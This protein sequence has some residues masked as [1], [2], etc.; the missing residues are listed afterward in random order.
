MA[1]ENLISIIVPV[2]KVE[3]FLTKCVNSICN[4]TYKQLEIILVDDGSPDKC[5]QMCDDYA[6]KDSRVRVIHQKN[7]GLSAARNSGIDVARGKYIM[8]VDSDDSID[9]E[10]CQELLEKM[11]TNDV[12]IVSFPSYTIRYGIVKHKKRTG[13]FTIKKQ[14][15]IMEYYLSDNDG[16]AWNKLYKRE[17]IGN[18]RY[19]VGR[20]AEDCATTYK[21]AEQAHSIGYLDKEMYCYYKNPASLSH[22]SFDLQKRYDFYLAFKERYNYAL[23]HKVK[24][25]DLCEGLYVRAALSA[26][27]AGY[28]HDVPMTDSRMQELVDCVVKHRNDKSLVYMNPK[29]RIFAKCCG[30]YD[31]VHKIGAKV[32][33]LA[34]NIKK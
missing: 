23:E 16:T 15:E 10:T 5:P 13:S 3:K 32:S 9:P 19:P 30:K 31:F 1:D 28:A 11:L 2:Y 33:K 18:I 4:Q 22:T 21:I 17:V 34:K 7:Q 25:I 8:F 14:P 12:D 29:Y 27:T 26:L 24:C 6:Q 20:I